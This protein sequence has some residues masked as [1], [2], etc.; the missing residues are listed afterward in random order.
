VSVH[1][2]LEP[3]APEDGNTKLL[4]IGAQ[5]RDL[6][7]ARGMTITALAE[8]IGRSS[9]YI[10]LIER[11]LSGISI[12]CLQRI[13]N[14]LGVQMNWFFQGQNDTPENEHGI[15]VRRN[16]RRTLDL[17]LMGITEE[18]LSPTL[19][20]AAELTLTTFSP[21]STTGQQ[22]RQRK[23]EEAG[24]VLKGSLEIWNESTC[25]RLYEGDSFTFSKPGKHQCV[26]IGDI[27]AIV[28][29][30]YTPPSY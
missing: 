25:Y 15:I 2:N 12:S 17:G 21:G 4:S 3:N 23:G 29:W 10:S 22:G 20:G 1:P 11:D 18:L 24:F 19:T 16:N 6:R 5:V 7:K 26:N 13:S 30:V 14:T 8:G 9:G 27:D 28:I